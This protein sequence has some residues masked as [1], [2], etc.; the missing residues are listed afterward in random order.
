MSR[1][2]I[3]LRSEGSLKQRNWG[4]EMDFLREHKKA[5][6]S[7]I[8]LIILAFF[9]FQWWFKADSVQAYAVK[10]QDYIPSLLTSG[11]VIPE[12]STLLS[13]QTAGIVVQC[14][15]SK[16]DPVKK[17]QVLLQ[18]DDRQ[19]RVARDRAVG[20]LQIARF[21]LQ[22]ATTVTMEGT[23]LSSVQADLENEQA[24]RKYDRMQILVQAG[25]VSEQE[26]ELAEQN[27]NLA[28]E[29]AR[30]VKIAWEALQKNGVS[31]A[32]LQTELQQR[33]L[34]LAEKELLLEQFQVLA[35]L[36]G[37]IM[38]VYARPGELLQAGNKVALVASSQRSRVR[39]KPDQRYA[40][41]ALINNRAKVWISSD[42]QAK[43]PAEVVLTDPFGNPDQGSV[44]AELSLEKNIPDLYPGR[45]VSVQLFGGLEKQAIIV[46][47]SYWAVREG[48]NG[49]WIVRSNKA[50][51]TELQNGLRTPEGVL[52]LAGLQEGDLL[53]K[54][55]G[56]QE[57]QRVN[58]QIEGIDH[59]AQ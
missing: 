50:H 48:K 38:D 8:L 10:K 58:P 52:I 9:L 27:L 34:D 19:A 24:Q 13:T 26:I 1:G 36:D 57:G 30:S 43:W 6:V 49:V 53:L 23:R 17:G 29:R 14:F 55:V 28:R 25:A 16:G 39:I 59:N 32:I 37:E 33:Q 51:F 21:N 44:T 31:L 20:A 54:P 41:L 18:L 5:L 7:G 11:E 35:P 42:A 40:A 22:E 2:K 12:S 47:D 46:P 45:L 56:L 15:V 3:I 4:T